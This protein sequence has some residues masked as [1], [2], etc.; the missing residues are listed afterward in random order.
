MLTLIIS[1]ESLATAHEA[2]ER[3]KI[4]FRSTARLQ[5]QG[6]DLPSRLPPRQLQS[7][8]SVP[9]SP[10]EIGHAHSQTDSDAVRTPLAVLFLF[11]K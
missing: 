8:F 1:S 2:M 5:S 6:L 11:L 9:H 4:L 7:L 10:S 3:T